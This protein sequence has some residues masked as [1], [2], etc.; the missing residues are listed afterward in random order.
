MAKL[1]VLIDG[2]ILVYSVGFSAEKGGSADL[3]QAKRN[4]TTTINSQK[5][6]VQKYFPSVKD[7]DFT[8]FLTSDD[9][10]NF[11][12]EVAT[13]QPYKGNRKTSSKPILYEEIREVLQEKWDATMVHDQE[14]DDEMA[15]RSSANP[16]KTIIVSKDKDLRMAPGWHWEMD[17]SKPPY[18]T[19]DIGILLLYRQPAGRSKVFG[20]GMKWFYF[21]C[22]VGDRVDNIPG[23]PRCGDKKAYDALKN[24]NTARSLQSK[25]LDIYKQAGYNHKRLREV[26]RLLWMKRKR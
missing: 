18:Y 4:L 11:R 24:C 9:K 14:A 10:S 3:S 23:I 22:L 5:A 12:F 26:K 2:D 25:V 17:P 16:E 8:F 21:Q 19:E 7:E 13:I 1:K 15:I 20:T 6:F